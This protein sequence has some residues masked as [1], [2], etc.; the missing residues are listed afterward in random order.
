[1]AYRSKNVYSFPRFFQFALKI[2]GIPIFLVIYI[3]CM[4]VDITMVLISYLS[5]SPTLESFIQDLK[6]DA[7]WP[8]KSYFHHFRKDS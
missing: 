4:L 7:Y 1:M 2:V 6:T 3:W 8:I 5:E